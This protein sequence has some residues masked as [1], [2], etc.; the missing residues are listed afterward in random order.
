MCNLVIEMPVC[1]DEEVFIVRGLYKITLGWRIW[2]FFMWWFLYWIRVKF[3]SNEI[4]FFY[5]FELKS[6]MQK[7]RLLV[8]LRV[9]TIIYHQLWYYSWHTFLMWKEQK[10]ILYTNCYEYIVCMKYNYLCISNK[11]MWHQT[12]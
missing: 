5:C 9:I 8:V 12:H 7:F 1:L 3:S 11:L 10:W 2:K 6:I 4:S